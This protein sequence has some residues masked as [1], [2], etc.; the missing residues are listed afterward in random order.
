MCVDLQVIWE[1]MVESPLFIDH[2][3]LCMFRKNLDEI[4]IARMY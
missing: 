2:F 1:I 3:G 4:C